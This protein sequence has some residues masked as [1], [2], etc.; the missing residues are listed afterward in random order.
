MSP[1]WKYDSAVGKIIKI[2]REYVVVNWENINGDWHYTQEQ[3]K[4]LKVVNDETS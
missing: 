1:M 3:A 2:N 4:R